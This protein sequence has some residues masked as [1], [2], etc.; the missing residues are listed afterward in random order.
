MNLDEIW[1]KVTT[2]R[3]DQEHIVAVQ[4]PIDVWRELLD[5]IQQMEQR[6]DARQRLARLR[7]QPDSTRPEST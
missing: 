1:Q 7:H 2:I 3:D 5:H 6:E 4:L